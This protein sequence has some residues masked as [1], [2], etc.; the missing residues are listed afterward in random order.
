MNMREMTKEYRLSH[1]AE[2]MAERQASGLS[3]TAYCLREG[4]HENRY[5]YWQRKLREV[6]VREMAGKE[7]QEIAGVEEK[8][9]AAIQRGTIPTGWAQAVTM[10][11]N[12]EDEGEISI[13]IGKSRIKVSE[14][15]NTGLLEK[16]CKVLVSLC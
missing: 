10:S 12:A 11:K 3:I 4:M 5:Y 6:A 8:V 16:V 2:R 13:E 9:P 14:R 1:W 15:T 7:G